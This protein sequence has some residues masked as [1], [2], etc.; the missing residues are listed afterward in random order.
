MLNGI[1]R[2]V[3]ELVEFARGVKQAVI[4]E[5]VSALEEEFIEL[6]SAFLFM[7]LGPLVGI[8]TITP[9]LSLEL[10]E[11][12]SAEIKI[13]ESRAFKGEDVLSDLMASLGGEW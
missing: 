8:K 4:E 3:R 10:L 12:L 5:S 7:I 13:L 9:L 6:E 2:V 1:K 11:S